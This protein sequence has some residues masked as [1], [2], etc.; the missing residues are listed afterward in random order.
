MSTRAMRKRTIRS[1]RPEVKVALVALSLLATVAGWMGLSR[2]DSTAQGVADTPATAPTVRTQEQALPPLPPLP[3]VVP[4]P[5]T[6]GSQALSSQVVQA[7]TFTSTPQVRRSLRKG[8]TPRIR[9]RVRT[10]SSR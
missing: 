10:R 6:T 7:P 8:Q 3:T 5:E 1:A 9:V 4:P 2:G